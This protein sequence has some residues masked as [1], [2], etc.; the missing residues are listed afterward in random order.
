MCDT[1]GRL[2]PWALV[3]V[4]ENSLAKQRLSVFLDPRLREALL[5]A[6]VADVFTTLAASSSLSGFAVVTVDPAVQRLARQYGGRV[7][8][9]G[10]RSGYN[11]AAT[12]GTQ[13]LVGRYA[14]DAVLTMPMDIPLITTGDIEDIIAAHEQSLGGFTL[15]PSRDFSGTNA[16][17]SSPP[18]CV[19]FCF[20]N[21]SFT[22]HLKSAR[23]TGIRPLIVNLPNVALDIDYPED[24]R[25][26]LEIPRE[27]RTRAVLADAGYVPDPFRIPVFREAQA[28]G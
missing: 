17:L 14:A 27:T 15:V 20:G 26:L 21:D 1:R 13:E 3:P 10:A 22:A 23:T 2:K 24:L 16:T 7:I 6:M 28:A 5:A 18:G 9:T 25:R 8:E 12:R 11:V 4:K 19:E